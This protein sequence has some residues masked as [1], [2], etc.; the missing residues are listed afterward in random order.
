MRVVYNYSN[1]DEADSIIIYNNK[2]EIVLSKKVKYPKNK[3]EDFVSCKDVYDAF[4]IGKTLAVD[5][6][7][8][9]L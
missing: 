1:S 2:N 6:E 8:P 3:K 7:E 9:Q 4:I 5:K